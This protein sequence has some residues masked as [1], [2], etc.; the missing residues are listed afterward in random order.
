MKVVDHEGKVWRVSRRWMP[1][2]RR[3]HMPDWATSG[4]TFMPGEVLGGLVNAV[5]GI[6]VFVPVLLWSLVLLLEVVLMLLVT[7]FVL[8]ARIVG[9]PW[10]VE[11]RDR[12]TF[13]WETMAGDWGRSGEVIDEVAEILRRG[14]RPWG[15]YP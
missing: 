3:L 10:P 1:W 8:L 9:S 4:T 5:V 13:A 12:W 11:V 6:V 14:D 15:Y 7:P 2:R